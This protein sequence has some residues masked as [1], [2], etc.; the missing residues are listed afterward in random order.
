LTLK[1]YED[2]DEKVDET[3][4]GGLVHPPPAGGVYDDNDHFKIGSKVKQAH[5]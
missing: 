5:K 2:E 1:T 4:S 3:E